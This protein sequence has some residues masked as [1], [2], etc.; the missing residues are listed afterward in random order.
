MSGSSKSLR[1]QPTEPFIDATEWSPTFQACG[2]L[3]ALQ[4]AVPVWRW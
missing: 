3:T 2:T 4:P 1:Y